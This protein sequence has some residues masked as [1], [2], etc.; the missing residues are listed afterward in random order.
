MQSGASAGTEGTSNAAAF[1][2]GVGK[3]HG[4]PQTTLGEEVEVAAQKEPQ[5]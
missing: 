1:A 3:T 4:H 5:F 2:A